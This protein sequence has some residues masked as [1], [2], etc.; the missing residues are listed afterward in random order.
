MTQTRKENPFYVG[1]PVPPRYF[2]GRGSE[3]N[4]AFDQISNGSH[5]ALWGGPGMG[6]SSFL[7]FIAEPQTWIDRQYD[8]S[9]ALIVLLNCSTINPF[10]PGAFWREILSKLREKVEGNVALRSPIEVILQQLSIQKSDVQRVLRLIGQQQQFLVLLLDDYHAALVANANYTEEEMTNF[11]S[12]FRNLAINGEESR[13]LSTIVTSL[14]RLNEL[15]PEIKFNASPWY[16][17][18][19]FQPLKPFTQNDV[20]SWFYLSDRITQELHDGVHE[21]AGQHPALLQTAYYLLYNNLRT[22]QVP[23]VEAFFRNFE[24]ATKHFLRDMWVFSSPDEQVLMMLIALSKLEGRLN[25]K[26][27][28]D[29]GD[30]DLIFSQRNREL[31]DLEERGLITY[32]VEQGKFAIA[33][34]SSLMEW[35]VIK[36]IENSSTTTELVTREKVMLNLMSRKQA[37]KIKTVM[38]QVWEHQDTIQSIVGW[39]SKLVSALSV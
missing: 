16:N 35:W 6:K 28:Y 14:R 3:V 27:K 32:K 12:E 37:E 10:T 7:R 31:R 20:A 33:F 17:H 8:H 9:Q 29:L 1:G 24:S 34:T 38:V 2:V 11:L 4:I 5:L 15:G 21:V 22:G 25:R 26:R 18:Y 36:E 13:Y 19:L 23:E 39:V 30:M